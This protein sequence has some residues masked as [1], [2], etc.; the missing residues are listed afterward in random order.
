MP[1][2]KPGCEVGP[3]HGTFDMDLASPFDGCH[4]L[5]NGE[6]AGEHLPTTIEMA[7]SSE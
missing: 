5:V 6:T 1:R 2:L 7:C 3:Q 4:R